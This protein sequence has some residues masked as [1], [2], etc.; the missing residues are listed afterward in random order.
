[1]VFITLATLGYGV[2]FAN[3]IFNSVPTEMCQQQ[4]TMG[5]KECV[6]WLTGIP[7]NF[8]V[9]VLTVMNI[10]FTYIHLEYLNEMTEGNEG[11]I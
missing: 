9:I 11:R 2:L 6:S 1:M 8:G 4:I 7:G 5:K 3:E 10:Y